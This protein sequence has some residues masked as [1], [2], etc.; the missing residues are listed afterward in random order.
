ML[1][2]PALAA[3]HHANERGSRA[4][5]AHEEAPT[6]KLQSAARA[7]YNSYYAGDHISDDTPVWAGPV[8]VWVGTMTVVSEHKLPYSVGKFRCVILRAGG[9]VCVHHLVHSMG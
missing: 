6:A 2:K 1:A 8:A 3:A 5:S 7:A 4:A 9:S